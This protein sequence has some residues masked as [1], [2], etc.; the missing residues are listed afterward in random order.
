MARG[1]GVQG[2][3]KQ[4]GIDEEIN[5]L[6]TLEYTHLNF[7]SRSHRRRHSTDSTDLFCWLVSQWLSWREVFSFSDFILRRYSFLDL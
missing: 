7:M 4:G 1:S 6:S 5:L 2:G 3:Q